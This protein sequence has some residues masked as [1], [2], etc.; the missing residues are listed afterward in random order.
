M[1]YVGVDMVEI[2]RI[3]EAIA[4][5]GEVF[6][7]RIYTP[8]ELANYRHKLPS[9]AVR[10]SAKEAAIKAL[11]SKGLSL[12]EIEILSAVD[13]KPAL[14][15]HGKARRRADELGLDTLDVSLS[16]TRDYAVA[17]VVGFVP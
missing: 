7:S 16:H 15:L 6:L 4:A 9:L 14:I 5:R 12:K 13:G 17:C 1:Q 11:G 8:A 3:G 2:S 10:F